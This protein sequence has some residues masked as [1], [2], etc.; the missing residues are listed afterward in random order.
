MKCLIGV[1]CGMMMLIPGA[2]CSKVLDKVAQKDGGSPN[3]VT[4]YARALQRAGEE[5]RFVLMN[6]TGSDWCGWCIKLDQEVFSRPAFIDFARENL[7]LV[8]VDYP[9]KKPLPAELAQQN[10]ALRRQYGVQGFPTIVL[11][12]PSGNVIGQTGYQPGGPGKFVKHLQRLIEPH[13]GRFGAPRE[14]APAPKPFEI[15]RANL[16]EVKQADRHAIRPWRIKNQEPVE[17]VLVEVFGSIVE[18]KGTDGRKIVVGLSSL[19]PEDH[20]FL[21]AIK[22]ID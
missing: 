13:A 4:D 21:I 18:L 16:P 6:F 19:A 20:A 15:D 2:S 22:A 5:N 10:E 17:A 9:Q 14:S 8:Y 12:D 11:L 1:A 7:I 3:W